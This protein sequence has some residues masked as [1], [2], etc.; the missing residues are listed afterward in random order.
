MS[1]APAQFA[2][3]KLMR[4]HKTDEPNMAQQAADSRHAT[5]EVATEEV[6]RHMSQEG[7]TF[8]SEA[9]CLGG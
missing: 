8:R 2:Y 5:E 4:S 7:F 6:A 3:N 9:A 1:F